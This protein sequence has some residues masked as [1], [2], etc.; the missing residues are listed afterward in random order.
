MLKTIPLSLYKKIHKVMPIPCADIV[1]ESG[2]QFLLAKRTNKPA[3]G[4][5]WFPGG[6]VNKGELLEAAAKR[7][8]KEELGIDVST[9]KK[10]GGDETIFKNGP[11]GW[12]THT[13]NTVFLA[14]INKNQKII[15]DNQNS[16][17][18]WFSKAGKD[19]HPYVKKFIKVASSL[20]KK[21]KKKPL[22]D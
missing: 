10:I 17:F 13:I 5:W 9:I 18:K 4:M 20:D 6:R 22:T 7:K 8:I 15:L 14:K 19:F 2:N 16:E 21:I 3:R 11:F 12:G 1:I